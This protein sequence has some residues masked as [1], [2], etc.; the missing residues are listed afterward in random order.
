[1]LF[2]KWGTRILGTFAKLQTVMVSFVMPAHPLVHLQRTTQLPQDGFDKS[3]TQN[4]NTFCPI[5]SFFKNRTV[6]EIIR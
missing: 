6:Y 5:I 4:Q 2:V 3:C 1:V